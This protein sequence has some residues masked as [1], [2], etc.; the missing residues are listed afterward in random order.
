MKIEAVVFDLDNT[1]YPEEAY[2]KAIFTEFSRCNKIRVSIFDFL[3]EDFNTIRFTKKDIFKFA[4]EQANIYFDE[5]HNQLFNL[6]IEIDVQINPYEGAF[7]WIKDCLNKNLKVGIL[8]NGIVKAQQN[9]WKCLGGN[10]LDVLF[11]PARQFEQEKPHFSSF[12]GIMK[13]LN[14]KFE[15]TLFVGDR[16]E[17]DIQ[18]GMENGGFGLFIGKNESVNV[19]QFESIQQA[20]AYFKLHFNQ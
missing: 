19:S 13:K 1:I 9:K 8:T 2:F 15:N 12:E 3:F 18:Y 11:A 6:Y 5:F 20:F 10:D 17:N 7:E 4:L 14:C 16:F